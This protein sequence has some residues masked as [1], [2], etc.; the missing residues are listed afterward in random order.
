MVGG[1]TDSPAPFFHFL[2]ALSALSL[3][4][5]ELGVAM[6]CALPTVATALLLGFF[7]QSLLLLFGGLFVAGRVMPPGWR[8]AYLLNPLRYAAEA[9]WAEQYFCPQSGLDAGTC[10]TFDYGPDVPIT[11]VP[12]WTFVKA[13]MAVSEKLVWT[14]V[15][16]VVGFGAAYAL[17]A[18]GAR[19]FLTHVV[20]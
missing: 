1:R 5:H 2:A 10:P 17:L 19:R 20:R 16:V 4:Y 15:A 14:N 7:I 3:A 6:A 12:I 11:G 8:G 18:A 9:V 13:Q